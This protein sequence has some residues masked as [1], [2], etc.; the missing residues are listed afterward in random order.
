MKSSSNVIE[1]ASTVEYDF[2]KGSLSTLFRCYFAMMLALY[3]GGEWGG[4]GEGKPMC[5]QAPRVVAMKV[6]GSRHYLAFPW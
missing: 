4:K 2:V 1:N 6:V 3:W 5:R